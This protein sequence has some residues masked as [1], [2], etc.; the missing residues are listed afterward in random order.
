MADKRSLDSRVKLSRRA[1]LA[2][3]AAL[4][5]RLWTLQGRSAE[6][7]AARAD[8]QR[9]RLV[10]IPADRG[11]V[12][13]RS[14]KLLV[15]NIPT[16]NVVV[17]RADLP[18]DEVEQQRVL[19]R[20]ATL[21]NIPMLAKDA[22]DGDSIESIMEKA[23]KLPLLEAVYLRREIDEAT[24][25]LLEQ[26]QL[27]MPG[28]SVQLEARREYLYGPLVSHILGY[29]GPVPAEA[30]EEYE[31]RGYG[32][33]ATVGLSGVEHSYESV[34][35]GQDGKQHIEVD[36][37]GRRVR[38]VGA[39][40]E[41]K[42]GGNLILTLDTALQEAATKALLTG[43]ARRNSPAGSVVAIDPRDGAIRC[44]VSLPAYDNNVFTRGASDEELTAL[45]T[46]PNFPMVN[47]TIAG[48]YPPGSTFKMVT[49]SG[50]LQEGVINVDTQRNCTG[51]M[52][53]SSED[54]AQRWPFYCFRRSGHGPMTVRQALKHSCDIFFYQVGG[55]FEDFAGLG[56]DRL[57]KY[58]GLFGLGSMTG[59]DL[60]GEAAGLVPDPKWK[61]LTTHQ[62]WMT[63]DTYNSAIGQGD[64]LTTP[65]Q[66]ACVTMTV[67][68]GGTLYQPR[69]AEALVDTDGKELARYKPRV[70]RNVP[71]A[72]ENLAL[73][74][75]GMRL[76][77]SEGTAISLGIKEVAVA[78]KTGTAEFYGPRDAEGN[79]P[80][81]A[82][83][84]SF[85]PY[86]NPEI[87][88]VAMI[89]HSGEGAYF[90]VPVVAE[91]LRAYFGLTKG[92]GA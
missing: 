12:Y 17:V 22:G 28:I 36:V 75:E 67:A 4:G 20:A 3:F 51:T 1:M 6:S 53:V 34:L 24:A 27:A 83:F 38:L 29:V 74:R 32:A 59:V 77:V 80:T 23:N 64:V 72:A 55:G 26:Q 21:L 11:V 63:G 73:V 41:A 78:G 25:F 35:R 50:G 48:V 5:V 84:V 39:P 88:V 56:P 49:A 69:L 40:T 42:A 47:R 86:E 15:R 87:V 14:G 37:L 90:A 65:L 19:E 31:A 18:D 45:G 44:L 61:R 33:S 43:M 54:G 58:A 2:A 85:A 66:M 13:D 8:Q 92:G 52:Y 46:D 79:L 71:V 10:S 62:Q 7:F 16:F 9:F 82:W 30:V 60:P 70:I 76:A 68:N 81:H 89:E 91:V 57:A